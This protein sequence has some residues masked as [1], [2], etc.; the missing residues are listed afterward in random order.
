MRW[1]KTDTCLLDYNKYISLPDLVEKY[2]VLIDIEGR[3]YS[4]RLKYLL[5]SHRPIIIIDRPHKEFFFKDLI[6]W[7]HYIPVKRDLTDL[8][9]NVKW[10]INNHD[11]AKIIAENAYIFS[12]K[13]LTREAC[14]EHWNEIITS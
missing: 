7:E 2:S 11:K 8:L 6:E 5:W 1:K 3:G 13:N 10:C 4:G 12:K 9:D 14:F